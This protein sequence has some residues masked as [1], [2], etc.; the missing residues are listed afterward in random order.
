ML[1]GEM[2]DPRV[3]GAGW[4]EGVGLFSKYVEVLLTP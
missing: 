1:N 4:M 3:M 2:C